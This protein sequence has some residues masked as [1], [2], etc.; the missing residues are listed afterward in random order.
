MPV[1]V[2][3]AAFLTLV[4]ALSA[5]PAAALDATVANAAV[6]TVDPG[7]MRVPRSPTLS[8]PVDDSTYIVGPG[9]RFSITVWGQGVVS[10]SA[11]VTPEGELV[12]PGIAIIPV[13]GDALEDVKR[14][15][16]GHLSEL[17]HDV[18]VSVSL[19]DLRS[20]LVNVLGQVGNPGTY[21]GTPLD[22]AGE[23]LRKAGGLTPGAS[24]RNIAVTRRSGDEARVDLTRYENTGDIT[25]NPPVLDGDVIFVPY[26]VAFVDV[27]GAVGSPG[28]FEL[29]E[30]ETVA[31][32]IELAGG[33]ARG[34]VTDSV[35]VRGFTGGAQASSVVV[36][37]S[38]EAYAGRLLADG[39]Q[40][41]VREVTEWRRV[42]HVAV[43]GE[44][45]RPGPYGIEEGVDR[46]SDVVRRAG[47]PTP[48]AWLRGARLVR[49][50]LED[51]PDAEFERL[52]DM[53]VSEMTGLEYPYF[54]SRQRDRMSVISDFEKALAGDE[55]EDAL[56]RDGDLILIPRR[57]DTVEVLGQ[58][59]NPGK[60]AHLSG[61]R[62]GHYISEAG[63]CGSLAR[64]NRIR[65]VRGAT[66]EWMYARSAGVLE[67]GDLVWVPERGET[68][69][70]KFV[71]EAAGFITSVVTAYV[72]IDQATK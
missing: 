65:V 58:V 20:M 18:E 44:V 36:D 57:V 53:P 4:A 17:Y 9:D 50:R 14:D 16:S 10:Y 12:L 40:V 37:M 60:I 35:E 46:L 70:W 15:I 62:Y 54:K 61:K 56:L 13:A 41:Y 52:S 23:F 69:W 55:S 47:G 72:V 30:G 66:G 11:V 21:L 71:R 63:G 31:S 1:R 26:A 8:G 64:K 3:L 34:A 22:L 42:T 19:T 29:T 25:A 39:D 45:E 24:T 48:E 38:A 32:L 68:D 43:E 6:E 67:P 27:Y 2:L 28:T 7:E 51:D 49:P 59:A 5:A 33:F